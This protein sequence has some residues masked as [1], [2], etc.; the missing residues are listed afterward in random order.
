M[1]NILLVLY[2]TIKTVSIPMLPLRGIDTRINHRFTE[3]EI[4]NKMIEE[5]SDTHEEPNIYNS[6]EFRNKAY[7]GMTIKQIEQRW[8]NRFGFMPPGYGFC[9]KA[10]C[11]CFSTKNSTVLTKSKHAQK[12]I[13]ETDMSLKHPSYKVQDTSMTKKAA[14]NK[15]EKIINPGVRHQNLYHKRHRS[16]GKKTLSYNTVN[17]RRAGVLST[18]GKGKKLEKKVKEKGEGKEKKR[19]KKTPEQISEESLKKWTKRCREKNRRKG[20]RQGR[21]NGEKKSKEKTRTDIRR[22]PKEEVK[23]DIDKKIEKRT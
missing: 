6:E 21:R 22:K 9:D 14:T 7:P 17:N 16:N 10:V 20:R 11:P 15:S 3:N 23:R 8:L 19:V 4:Q 13:G 12:Q 2:N 18:G 5:N 1:Q